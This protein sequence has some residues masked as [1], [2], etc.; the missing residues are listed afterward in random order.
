MLKLLN[1]VPSTTSLIVASGPG[2]IRVLTKLVYHAVLSRYLVRTKKANGP[3]PG[4]L[5]HDLHVGS[6][7][8]IRLDGRPGAD[9]FLYAR[10]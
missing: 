2:P 8:T 4:R 5:D 9:V 7:S 1:G 3:G 6:E 10:L